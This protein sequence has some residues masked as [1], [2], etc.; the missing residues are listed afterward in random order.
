MKCHRCRGPMIYE[1]LY[2]DDEESFGWKCIVCG[3]IIDYTILMNRY[4]Q[5]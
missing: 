1:R 5:N 2:N 4:E 3:E